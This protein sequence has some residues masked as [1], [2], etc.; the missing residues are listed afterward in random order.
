MKETHKVFSNNKAKFFNI[1]N[2]KDTKS[3]D[4]V[5]S[6]TDIISRLTKKEDIKKNK[7][8]M[9]QLEKLDEVVHQQSSH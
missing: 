4:Y 5:M 8:L 2:I 7:T 6:M 3:P 1:D 9:Y